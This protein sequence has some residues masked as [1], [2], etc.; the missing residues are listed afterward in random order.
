MLKVENLKALYRGVILALDGVS[1]ELARGEA[2]AVLGPNGAGKST[3]VR[4][5]AGLLPSYEGRVSDG[6]IE[7]G[8]RDVTAAGALAVHR[9]GLTAVLEG[10]PI[11]RYL[12][13][14]ENLRA[15]GHRLP[16]GELAARMDEVFHWFPRLAE[17][18]H[19]QGGYLSGGEQQ[20]LVLGM[21]LIT[22]PK[23]LVVDEPSLGLAPL[24]VEELFEVLAR[25]HREKGMALLLVE[26]NARAAMKLAHRVYVLEHG[27]VVFEGEREAAERDADVMEFYLGAGAGGFLGA[28][29]YRR[30]KRWI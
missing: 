14:R 18:S 8:G 12:T 30:R 7:L 13:V 1:L 20:M 2:V 21:A 28:K 5:L 4:A 10:R 15:A 16:A 23:V 9:Q 11:F 24:L 29:R 17:R 26:Q 6:R 3:L 22:D 27:R 19:E 25:M